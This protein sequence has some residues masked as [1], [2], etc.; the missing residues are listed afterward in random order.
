MQTIIAKAPRGIASAFIAFCAAAMPMHAQSLSTVTAPVTGRDAA[1]MAT[2]PN[3]VLIHGAWADASSWNGVIQR[4]QKAGYQVTAVQLSLASLDDDVARTRGVLASQTGPTLL[5]AHSYGGA[6]ITQLGPDA[7]NVVGLVYESAFAPD[8]GGLRHYQWRSAAAETSAIRPDNGDL[9]LDREGLLKFFAPDVN[10][11]EARMLEAVQTPISAGAL[12]G[13]Q[14]FG[15]P[16][17]KSFPTWFLITENDQML[18]PAAQHLFAKRMNATVTSV[19]GSHVSMVSHPDAVRIYNEGRASGA[20]ELNV[21]LRQSEDARRTDSAFCA[22]AA[23][24]PRR[25]VSTELSRTKFHAQMERCR[26]RG[27]GATNRFQTSPPEGCLD[28]IE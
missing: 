27:Q 20:S 10:R 5:V 12:L 21:V 13:D 24:A 23:N 9:W 28:A 2:Q 4:L 15:P 19:A 7:P 14:K 6:V 11:T 18:P 22:R 8:E 25:P 26:P 16:A 1:R 3:I 17:W